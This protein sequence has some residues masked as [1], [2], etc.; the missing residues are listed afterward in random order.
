[1]LE[2]LRILLELGK[3]RIAS[4]S[5]LSVLAG[6]VLASGRVDRGAVAA[7]AGV[8]LLACGAAAL[9]QYQERDIDGR[10]ERTMRR[11]LPSGRI[12]P[13]SALAAAALMMLSGTACLLPDW[14]AIA[15]GW[16]TIVWYNGVYTPLKRVTAFAAVP[17]GVVGAIPPAIGWVCGG[18]NLAD[19]R[20]AAVSFFFFVWQIPHFWLLL[21][22]VG[23]DYR[24]AGMPVLTAI[25]SRGQLSRI[26]YVWLLA[27][28]VASVS[29][30]LFGLAST[31]WIYAGFVT[32]AIWLGWHATAML[33]SSGSHLAFKET[34]LFAL[35]VISLLSL[36]GF[37]K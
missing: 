6:Y 5:M 29:L 4:L 32:A 3:V 13:R 25:F 27:A 36:S 12:T 17:G 23:D 34:N 33:R 21:M 1:M 35:I 10:M 18:G 26:T 9:N 14:R 22:K 15:L 7:A 20:I 37:L 8:F 24:R 31:W 11:P 2:K 19:P 16:F 28:G 30:A